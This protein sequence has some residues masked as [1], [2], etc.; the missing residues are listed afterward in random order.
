MMIRSAQFDSAECSMERT[1]AKL[2]VVRSKIKFIYINNH[3]S[4]FPRFRIV[5]WLQLT[6]NK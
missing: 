5:R 1:R 6:Q 4:L 2:A 3:D